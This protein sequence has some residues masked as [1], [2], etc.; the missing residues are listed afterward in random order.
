MK[1]N[2]HIKYK[3]V[4]R[5]KQKQEEMVNGEFSKD[6]PTGDAEMSNNDKSTSKDKYA[7]ITND[8]PAAENHYTLF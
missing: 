2:A 5:R 7:R 6:I 4:W 8:D 1:V 3:K